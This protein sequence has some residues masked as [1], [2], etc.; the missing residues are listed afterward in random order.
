MSQ[1]PRQSPSR[2]YLEDGV[3][4]VLAGA[5]PSGVAPRDGEEFPFAIDPLKPWV[6]AAVHLGHQPGLQPHAAGRRGSGGRLVHGKGVCG[7]KPEG[8]ISRCAGRLLW[9]RAWGCCGPAKTLG[10]SLPPRT[11]GS[12]SP[13]P[14]G[15]QSQSP[16]QPQAFLSQGP[17]LCAVLGAGV[18]HSDALCQ[19]QHPLPGCHKAGTARRQGAAH[20]ETSSHCR[21]GPP[22]PRETARSQ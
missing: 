12:V 14:P 1:K 18:P 3:I 20:L 15:A 16:F 21:Q 5:V 19:I 7:T 17:C 4:S 9:Q 22:S 6:L 10:L 2:A 13:V 11:G 8:S